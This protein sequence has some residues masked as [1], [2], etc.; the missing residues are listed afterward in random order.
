MAVPWNVAQKRLLEPKHHKW[1]ANCCVCVEL[2]M[3]G[4]KSGQQGTLCIQKYRCDYVLPPLLSTGHMALNAEFLALGSIVFYQR[5]TTGCACHCCGPLI[6]PGVCC[7]QL[8]AQTIHSFTVIAPWSGSPSPLSA[9][10]PPLPNVVL[11]HTAAVRSGAVA[12]DVQDCLE[13]ESLS[14]APQDDTKHFH[15]SFHKTPWATASLSEQVVQ[16]I[17][18]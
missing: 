2:S 14:V 11:P 6:L 1:V 16:Y 12:T 15:L 8:R 10:S 4:C 13:T 9:R 3:A 18:K 5:G 17:G 7:H